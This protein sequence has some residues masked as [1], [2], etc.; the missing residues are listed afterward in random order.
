MSAKKKQKKRSKSELSSTGESEAG[1]LTSADR[2]MLEAMHDQIN[3]LKKLDLLQDMIRDIADLKTSVD[4]TNKLIEELKQENSFLKTTV[5]SLQTEMTRI[6]NENKQMKAEMLEIQCRSMRN[7]I[8][9]MGMKEEKKEDYKA[10]ENTVKEFMKADLKMSEQQ[11]ANISIERAHRLGRIQDPRKPRPVVVKF[12]NFNAKVEVIGQGYK[13]KGSDYS[14]FEQFPREIVARR[15]LLY[16]IM[17]EFKEKKIKVRLSVDKL[18]IN[19]ELYRDSKV[20]TWL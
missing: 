2:A 19:D 9:I 10:T 3:Q 18:Y 15:R 11:V 20:T 14:M 5:D 8:V 13:L 12:S 4:F 6:S 1:G 16:P 7:N 17:K